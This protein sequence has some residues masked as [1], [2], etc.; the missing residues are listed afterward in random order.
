MITDSYP[1]KTPADVLYKA[2]LFEC[3]D[4]IEKTVTLQSGAG[5]KAVE[6][7]FIPRHQKYDKWQGTL[8]EGIL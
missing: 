5:N 8:F 2:C 3:I 1:L 4:S 7:L 6:K